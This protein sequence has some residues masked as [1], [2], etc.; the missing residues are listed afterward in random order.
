[1]PDRFVPVDTTGISRYFMEVRPLIYRFASVIQ[2]TTVI[3]LRDLQLA[4]TLRN[5]LTAESDA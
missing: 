1:M 3:T 5:T 4:V 2:K